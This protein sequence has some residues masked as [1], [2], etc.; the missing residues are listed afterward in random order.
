MTLVLLTYNANMT[1]HHGT[2]YTE[3]EMH[4]LQV[5]WPERKS[6]QIVEILDGVHLGSQRWA[7][8]TIL[9]TLRGVPGWE[10]APGV[11]AWHGHER[12]LMRHGIRLCQRMSRLGYVDTLLPYILDHQTFYGLVTEKQEYPSWTRDDMIVSSHR[13]YLLRH[14]QL[15]W[16][17]WP[18]ERYDLPLIIPEGV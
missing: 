11:W 15:Y 3:E 9:R 5:I 18:N 8:L 14:S 6:S 13:A 10:H 1:C 12:A 4:G 2:A 7:V 17:H 16:D